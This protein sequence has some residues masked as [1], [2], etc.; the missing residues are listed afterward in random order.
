MINK[1]LGSF[2][3]KKYKINRNQN[4]EE[5]EWL[6]VTNKSL[7]QQNIKCLKNSNENKIILIYLQLHAILASILESKS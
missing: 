2:L 6:Q 1:T 4:N 3:K 7:I 5:K